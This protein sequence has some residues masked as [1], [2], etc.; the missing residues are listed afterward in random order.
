LGGIYYQIN[1]FWGKWGVKSLIVFVAIS[2][3][4]TF[5]DLRGEFLL[6]SYRLMYWLLDDHFK[7]I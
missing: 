1:I 6:I 7:S 4:D 3:Y 5:K 2:E